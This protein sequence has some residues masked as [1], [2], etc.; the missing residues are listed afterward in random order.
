[1]SRS[2]DAIVVD[3]LFGPVTRAFDRQRRAG[4][5]T[6]HTRPLLRSGLHVIRQ[7]RRSRLNAQI[8]I[9]TNGESNRQ[10]HMMLA[11][12]DRR[13]AVRSFCAK[14]GGASGT[15][16]L[17]QAIRAA[18]NGIQFVDE[19]LVPYFPPDPL[20]PT[21]DLLFEGDGWPLFWRGLALGARSHQ[22]LGKWTYYSP[23]TIRNEMGKM[24]Q[25]LYNIDPGIDP[26]RTP[27]TVA[28]QFA[29]RNWEFFVDDSV[30]ALFPGRWGR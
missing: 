23:K 3:I 14:T 7:A 27:T 20:R 9:W 21:A 25:E 8:V 5:I 29:S 19:E 22:E 18:I 4:E 11:K 6:L 16:K 30:A 12:Q 28:Q 1:M 26:R 15:R 24:V 10:L 17:V 13:L 2:F